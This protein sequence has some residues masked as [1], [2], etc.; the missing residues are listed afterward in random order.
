MF[1]DCRYIRTKY[2]YKLHIGSGN[3]V[4]N[5]IFIVGKW[6]GVFN[7]EEHVLYKEIVM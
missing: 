2:D 1:L 6:C 4:G 7:I 5:I 3:L